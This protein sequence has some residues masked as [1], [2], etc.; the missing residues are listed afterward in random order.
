M[1]GQPWDSA[2]FPLRVSLQERAIRMAFCRLRAHA[3]GQGIDAAQRQPAVERRWRRSADR[4]TCGPARKGSSRGASL[5]PRPPRR[6]GRRCTSWSSAPPCRCRNRA[7]LQHGGG[8]SAIADRYGIGRLGRMRA[9][10]QVRDLQERIRGRL[11]PAPAACSDASPRAPR[12]GRSYRHSWFRAATWQ[13][14]RRSPGAGRSRHR[15][16]R[17][18]GPP[19]PGPAINAVATASPDEKAKASLPPSSE[20]RHS[21]KRLAASD[22]PPANS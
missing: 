2:P 16:A 14:P 3:P 17:R 22:C 9:T 5:A 18:C 6:C 20:A 12:R 21:S 1:V 13:T 10:A 8:E 19:A 4:A 11:D 7:A 15:R